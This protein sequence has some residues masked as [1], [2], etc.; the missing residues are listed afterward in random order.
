LNLVDKKIYLLIFI[1]H[2]KVN[3]YFHKAPNCYFS[4]VKGKLKYKKLQE[5]IF[6][7]D[8][9]KEFLSKVDNGAYLHKY[10]GIWTLGVD[11]LPSGDQQLLNLFVYRGCACKVEAW[12]IK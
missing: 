9:S 8:I 10:A 1:H 4:L 6:D 12:V 5:Q 2:K 3:N 7:E 11:L